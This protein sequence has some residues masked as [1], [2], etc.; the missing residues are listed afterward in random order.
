MGKTILAISGRRHVFPRADHVC[1]SEL[2]RGKVVA[3][4]KA[5]FPTRN[6]ALAFVVCDFPRTY[7]T[8]G[9]VFPRVGVGVRVG[10]GEANSQCFLARAVRRC[11]DALKS[12]GCICGR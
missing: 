9:V 6:T 12:L 2:D 4:V 8:V 11:E 10:V 3:G 7:P 5:L 1:I